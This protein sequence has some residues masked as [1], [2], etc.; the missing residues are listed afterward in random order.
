MWSQH[1]ALQG[2]HFV[3]DFDRQTAGD[4][5]RLRYEA[6]GRAIDNRIAAIENRRANSPAWKPREVFDGLNV[7]HEAIVRL[8]VIAR[9]AFQ[10]DDKKL[11]NALRD[12]RIQQALGMI[13]RNPSEL[14]HTVAVRESIAVAA[15]GHI[16]RGRATVGEDCLEGI[17]QR[18]DAE[19]LLHELML[20]LRVRNDNLQLRFGRDAINDAALKWYGD[21]KRERRAEVIRGVTERVP[22]DE[23]AD[24]LRGFHDLVQACFDTGGEYGSVEFVAAALLKFIQ[25]VKQKMLSLPVSRHCMP[26]IVGLQECGKTVFIRRLLDPIIEVSVP[27]DFRAI[28]EERNFDIW[29]NHALYFDEMG[30]STKSEIDIIKN[31]VTADTL[32]RRPMKTNTHVEVRQRATFIGSANA[33][34]LGELIRDTTGTRRFVLVR[35]SDAPDWDAV[36]AF[37]FAALWRAVDPRG[38]DPLLPHRDVLLERQEEARER[39]PVECWFETIRKKPANDNAAFLHATFREYEEKHFPERRTNINTFGR[40]MR[41]LEKAGLSPFRHRRSERGS[42]YDWAAPVADLDAVREAR[43]QAQPQKGSF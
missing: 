28:V 21:A 30:Y 22:A 29:S 4:D 11:Q 20:D 15:N 2:S 37:D 7:D 14:V 10:I 31:V 13:P 12:E 34:H 27:A 19:V 32:S 36:N 6:D 5:A 9:D 16:A 24:T 38:P 43:Q 40:E 35:Y 39:S 42:H 25:Q 1:I 8:Y 33:E 18:L 3:S 17:R 41:R 26:V 23:A